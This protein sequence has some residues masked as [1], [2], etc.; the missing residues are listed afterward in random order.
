[1]ISLVQSLYPAAMPHG[2]QKCNPKYKFEAV[3]GFLD[4]IE[5]NH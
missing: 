3:R 1:M 5:S 4:I 2:T